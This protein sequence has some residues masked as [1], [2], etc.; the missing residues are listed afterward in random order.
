MST[1]AATIDRTLSNIGHSARGVL[2]E[3][4]SAFDGLA[5]SDEE[6]MSALATALASTAILHHREHV[7]KFLDAARIWALEYSDG[8]GGPAMAS[9]NPALPEM[10][11][12]AAELVSEGLEALLTA[13][14][15][16][17]VPVQDRAVA[18]LTLYTRLLERVE[19]H[20]V[21][22][23]FGAVS[24]AMGRPGFRAGNLV[25]VGIH[26]PVPLDGR[27]DLT[28]LPTRGIA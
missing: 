23:I 5:L 16:A 11:S 17:R 7:P 15:H 9:P 4:V 18:E 1:L 27:V 28:T 21:L 19:A 10:V 2:R 24:V 3:T 25:H 20:L 14:D 6:R 26:D 12:E 13:L 22:E 8:S